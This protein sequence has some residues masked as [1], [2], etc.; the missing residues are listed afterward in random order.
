MEDAMSDDVVSAEKAQQV[1]D[2]VNAACE[3][4]GMSSDEEAAALTME[5]LARTVIAL[6]AREAAQATELAVL[7]AQLAPLLAV[8]D[9]LVAAAALPGAGASGEAMV[10]AVRAQASADA[11][12][13]L[14]R[15]G[16]L[17]GCDSLVGV[18]IHAAV[19]HELLERDAARDAA[20]RAERERDDARAEVE[21]LRAE[22][23]L[24]REQIGQQEVSLSA[25]I[26]R[27]REEKAELRTQVG[28]AGDAQQR[29]AAAWN[30]IAGHFLVSPS[31]ANAERIARLACAAA[32]V[33]DEATATRDEAVAEVRRLTAALAAHARHTD[34]A[35]D[36]VR[37]MLPA[38]LKIAR[39]EGA[40]GMRESLAKIWDT[41]ATHHDATADRFR[42]SRE[43]VLA[44][45][46]ERWAQ[47]DRAEAAAIRTLPLDA[48]GGER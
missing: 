29:I 21:T 35:V 23:D 39:E 33:R 30:Q 13:D 47:R 5:S 1:I 36:G 28:V 25:T 38:A 4:G 48:P 32:D 11:R 27:L 9:A 19:E 41:R 42:A 12:E 8:H 43:T 3:L 24:L 45:D 14:A 40:E 2:A 44:A 16:R 37:A 31:P 10:A 18:E 20:E 34:A 22:N 6:H 7:R 15:I 17:V 46:Y 26:G